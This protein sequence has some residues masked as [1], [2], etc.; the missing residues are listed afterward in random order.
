MDPAD[1]PPGMDAYAPAQIAR[2]VE[3]I[4]ITKAR[5]PL[6]Q[7]FA[8]AILAGGFIALGGIFFTVV[9]TGSSAGFGVTRLVGGIAFSLGLVLVIVGGAELFTGNNLLAM[10][11]A[12]G[13]IS[14]GEVARNWVVVYV[15]NFV[16]ALGAVGWVYLSGIA[17][18][19]EGSVGQTMIS[20]DRAK[21]ELGVGE[22]IGRGVLCNA[23]VCLAVW[24]CFGARSVA[25]K[26]LAIVF[27]I[28]AFV[29][30]GFEH[31]VANMYFLPMGWLLVNGTEAALPITGILQNLAAVTVGNILGGTGLVALAYWFI[32]LR[33][34]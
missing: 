29:A 32:Y 5:A 33:Q 25:D 11:W 27:P 19:A 31:S 17:A 13:K 22:A 30:C 2:R 10:A 1:F 9:V 23:L 7:T 8:L 15:G 4:G 24:L 34:A 28:T 12:A 18:L 26:I 3:S 16:G 14:L 6:A 20:I 21:A